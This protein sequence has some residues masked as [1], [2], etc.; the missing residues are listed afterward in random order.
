MSTQVVPAATDPTGTELNRLS[1]ERCWELLGQATVGRLGV[2]FNGAPDIFPVNHAVLDQTIVIRTAPGT[3]LVSAID[4]KVVFEVDHL[5]DAQQTGW[6]VVVHGTA[7]EPKKIEDYLTAIEE[8][9]TPWAAGERDRFIVIRPT[10]V[11]GRVLPP[12]ATGVAF[13]QKT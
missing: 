13:N 12:A 1:E 8:G 4:H 3:K 7:E 2:V 9:P 10:L 6:S 5:H 11:T